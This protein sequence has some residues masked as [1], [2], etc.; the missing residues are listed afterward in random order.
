MGPTYRFNQKKCS[1][2]SEK[3]DVTKKSKGIIIT[4]KKCLI[5]EIYEKKVGNQTLVG[6]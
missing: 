1:R 2:N 3:L 6:K 4:H 5:E